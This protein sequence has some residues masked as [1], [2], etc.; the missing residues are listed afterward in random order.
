MNDSTEN[1]E[2]RL[3]SFQKVFNEKE[4][5]NNGD[6]PNVVSG[7]GSSLAFSQEAMAGLHA[8]I[9]DI[10]RQFGLSRIRMLDIPCGDMTWMGRFLQTRDDIDYTGYDIVPELIAK[11]KGAFKDRPWKFF[12]HDIAEKPI[13]D[14]FDLIFSRMMLQ[15]L[16]TRDVLK[17]LT[18]FSDS[19]SKYLLTTTFS[20][21]SNNR[22]LEAGS[23]G[24]FRLLNLEIPPVSLV[25]PICTF[26]D[27]VGNAQHFLALW[28]LPLQKIRACNDTF[29]VKIIGKSY[30][31]HSC[32]NWTP[33]N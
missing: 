20:R 14:T 16:F 21:I 19:G 4:W 3:A 6:D 31:V 12:Q 27:G 28:N 25:P 15:H 24:R 13:E 32:T 1:A 11:H 26:R 22:D 9:S 30:N 18:R 5:I 33:E 7:A 23:K 8:V 29:I 10:R 2:Q 17:I